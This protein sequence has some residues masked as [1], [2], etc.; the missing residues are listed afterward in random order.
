LAKEIYFKIRVS[1]ARGDGALQCGVAAHPLD[2]TIDL[3]GGK[4]GRVMV[5]RPLFLTTCFEGS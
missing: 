1:G 2:P 3:R 5:T 4:Q